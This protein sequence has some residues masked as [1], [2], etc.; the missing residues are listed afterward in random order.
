M[1]IIGLEEHIATERVLDI[2]RTTDPH[3]T[4]PALR[5]TLGGVLGP[6]IE[7]RL[8]DLGADRLRAMDETGLDVQVLSLTTPGLSDMEPS[9]ALALQT[10][11]NDAIAAAI[12]AN[13]NRLQGFATLATQVPAA[14]ADELRRAV[15]ELGLSGAMLY[16]RTG[17]RHLDH[18][19]FWPIFEAADALRAPLYVHPQPP[20]A[21]VRAS[22]Y[23]GFDELT[24]ALFATGGIGW[25]YD[26]GIEILRM[27]VGGVFDRFPNLQVIAGHWGEVAL[28]YLDRLEI[29]HAVAKLPRPISDY[30]R[31]NI[32]V[33]P[34]G[35]LTQ[36]YLRWA[37]DVVGIDRIMFAS[38]YPY[39]YAGGSAC[40]R[41]L[42]EAD[43]SDTDREKIASANWERLRA[44]IRR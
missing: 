12:R 30:W 25:H 31:T 40:R 37:I 28:F 19:D 24:S 41:F 33:T 22:Y 26:T 6:E 36:R 2:W 18:P 13:P 7:G 5:L 34:G 1:K 44:D 16:G 20:P 35:I 3:L 10:E 21:Q 38:D 23:G 8:L 15:T 43:L 9:T 42:A 14:A 17:D 29:L 39:G 11:V 4:D 27:I 32:S